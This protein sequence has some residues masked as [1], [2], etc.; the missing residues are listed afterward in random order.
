MRYDIYIYIYVIRRL[1]VNMH[2]PILLLRIMPSGLLLGIVLSV[3]NFWS[4]VWW[5]YL[6]DL[7]RLILVHGHTIFRCLILSPISLHMLKCSSAHC[8]VSMYC[9][10]ATIGHADMM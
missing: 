2:V 3:R 7:F 10:F 1:K 8:H 5:L 4:I 6:H 9:S